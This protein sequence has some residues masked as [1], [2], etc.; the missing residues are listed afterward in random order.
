MTKPKVT[1]DAVKAPARNDGPEEV[2]FVLR[3]AARDVWILFQ[4]DE[5]PVPSDEVDLS[6]VVLSGFPRRETPATVEVE[7]RQVQVPLYYGL[8][9]I[10]Y[11]RKADL[12]AL[13]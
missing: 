7:G 10:D 1:T 13:L 11:V 5:G 8:G 6:T 3:D 12:D 2:Y 4:S 9:N